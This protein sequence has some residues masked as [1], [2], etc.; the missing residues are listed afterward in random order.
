MN[1]TIIGIGS[2]IDPVTNIKRA[3]VYLA[4]DHRLIKSS[5]LTVTRPIGFS[6]QPD[7]VNGAALLDTEMDAD[8]FTQYLKCIEE[9]LGRI[10]TANKNGP[11]TI[12]L[13][14]VIWNG[15]VVDNDFYTRDFLRNAVEE[16]TAQ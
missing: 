4:D 15:T 2:N 5:T 10:R 7:F 3:L 11:R 1:R 6:D 12:D 9:R 8:R 14:I 16:I 13:D